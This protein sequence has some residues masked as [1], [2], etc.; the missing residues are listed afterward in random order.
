MDGSLSQRLRGPLEGSALIKLDAR[1]A[2]ARGVALA[3]VVSSAEVAPRRGL[4]P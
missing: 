1:G 3:T 2:Y 4:E